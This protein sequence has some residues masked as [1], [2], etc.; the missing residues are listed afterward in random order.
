MAGE[1]RRAQVEMFNAFKREEVR[2][3]Y[4]G[5]DSRYVVSLV[6]GYT[7]DELESGEMVESGASTEKRVKGAAA[8]A[9]EL[10]RGMGSGDT[11]WYVHDR[12]SGETYVLEQEE[13]VDLCSWR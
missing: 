6:V 4:V 10:T 9:L 2:S 13:L 11:N 8:A 7:D 1:E 3:T 12:K 5:E